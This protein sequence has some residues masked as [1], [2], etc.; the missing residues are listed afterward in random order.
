MLHVAC[1]I[2]HSRPLCAYVPI[3]I[4]L[5]VIGTRGLNI[6]E[7]NSAGSGETERE[8]RVSSVECGVWRSE[9]GEPH[10]RLCG[11]GSGPTYLP[12]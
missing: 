3:R 10:P 2:V 11:T 8:S 4:I 5:D 7:K 12:T 9:N 6:E 1:R